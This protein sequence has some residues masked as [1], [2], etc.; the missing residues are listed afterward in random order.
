MPVDST[1]R[2]PPETDDAADAGHTAPV[3]AFKQA[4]SRLGEIGAY[5]RQYISAKTDAVKATARRIAILAVLGVIALFAAAAMVIIA[6]VQLLYGIAGAI[7]AGL[8][9]RLW[10]GEL[11]TGAGLLILLA[12]SVVVGLGILKKI[13]M[14]AIKAKYELQQRQQ[15]QQ[16]GRSSSDRAAAAGKVEL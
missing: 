16:F 11:I 15:R 13:S 4:F 5:G 8:G 12:A 1:Q 14:K 6:L 3:E 9:G 10:A 7:G 2:M